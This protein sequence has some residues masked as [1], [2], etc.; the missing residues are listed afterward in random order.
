MNEKARQASRDMDEHTF[1]VSRLTPPS[2]PIRRADT[3]IVRDIIENSD[4]TVTYRLITE[5]ALR[6]IA[7]RLLED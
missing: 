6:A 7:T 2:D 3:L 5:D 1:T 4:G